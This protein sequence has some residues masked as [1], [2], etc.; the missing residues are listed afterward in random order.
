MQ[1]PEVE[2]F[3]DKFL[4]GMAD[5]NTE[6]QIHPYET[7]NAERWY[8]WWGSGEPAFPDVVVD[9]E[10]ID[11]TFIAYREDGLKIDKLNVTTFGYGPAELGEE[12]AD[13]LCSI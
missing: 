8:Q 5:T 11:S 3:V 13:G 2:A 7:V 9:R 10:N 6:V 4:L 12:Q 1:R